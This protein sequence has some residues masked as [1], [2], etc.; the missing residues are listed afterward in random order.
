VAAAKVNLPVD[1]SKRPVN[2][3]KPTTSTP[4]NLPKMDEALI[5]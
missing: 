2:A 3:D 1:A 5:N 4:S